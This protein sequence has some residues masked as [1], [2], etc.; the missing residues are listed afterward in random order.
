M[1]RALITGISGFVGGHLEYYLRKRGWMVYGFDRQVTGSPQNVYTGDMTD[2]DVLKKILL[3]CRPDFVFHLAG[4]IKSHQPEQ[5][6]NGNLLGTVALLD[7]LI[8][9]DIKA[10]VLVA[11]SSAVYGSGFGGRPIS[12]KF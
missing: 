10:T 5:L 2:R 9:L 3:E 1:K 11:S 12:E 7:I 4:I 6:Y 8:E